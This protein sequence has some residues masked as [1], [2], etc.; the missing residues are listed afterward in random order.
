MAL[1]NARYEAKRKQTKSRYAR[2]ATIRIENEDGEVLELSETLGY[3]HIQV[4]IGKESILLDYPAWD[5]LSQC[6]W[7]LHVNEPTDTELAL[8]DLTGEDQ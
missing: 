4:R 7:E 6:R 1:N 2:L 8:N 3:Q 5:A